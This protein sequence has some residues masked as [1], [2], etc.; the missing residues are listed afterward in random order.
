MEATRC[1]HEL[2]L[3]L[4][5]QVGRGTVT[6]ISATMEALPIETVGRDLATL[7]ATHAPMSNQ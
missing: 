3:Q 1:G 5:L 4:Q 7:A 6:R 2:L